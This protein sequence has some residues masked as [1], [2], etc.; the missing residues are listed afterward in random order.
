M[1]NFTSSSIRRFKAI[2]KMYYISV[3]NL[4]SNRPV[5]PLGFCDAD[6]DF[7]AKV[8][9]TYDAFDLILYSEH[10]PSQ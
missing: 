5:A 3:N 8:C 2:T 9:T 10:C 7:A 4:S 6:C 1:I